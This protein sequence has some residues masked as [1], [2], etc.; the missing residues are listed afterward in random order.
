MGRAFL[1][2]DQVCLRTLYYVLISMLG[3][4]PATAPRNV[5]EV[6]ASAL[7]SQS[8]PPASYSPTSRGSGI[9]VTDQS[10]PGLQ[11]ANRVSAVPCNPQTLNPKPLT[12]NPKP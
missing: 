11:T 4:Q 7:N 9:E 5:W 2:D 12:L 1:P 10:K 8:T 6:A 3:A